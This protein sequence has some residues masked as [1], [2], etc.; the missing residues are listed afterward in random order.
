MRTAWISSRC[1]QL[2]PPIERPAFEFAVAYF[3]HS[4]DWELSTEMMEDKLQLES[5]QNLPARAIDP[6]KLIGLLRSQFGLGR[7]EI[8]VGRLSNSSKKGR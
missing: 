6:L 5:T 2:E 1:R 4:Q 7:Y 8:S 3:H